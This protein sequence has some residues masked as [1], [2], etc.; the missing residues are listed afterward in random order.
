MRKVV[1][2]RWFMMNELI[3]PITRYEDHQTCQYHFVH[4]NEMVLVSD[5]HITHLGKM[6]KKLFFTTSFKEAFS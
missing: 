5:D 2:G 6:V 4:I 1:T 3:S